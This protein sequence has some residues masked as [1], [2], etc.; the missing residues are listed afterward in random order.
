MT[1]KPNN[2]IKRRS[3]AGRPA[4]QPN[5][6][7][8]RT[9]C[10]FNPSDEELSAAIGVNPST[11]VIWKKKPEVLEAMQ[12]GKAQGRMSLR[13][14]QFDKAMKGSDTML[15]WLGKQLLDQKEKSLLGEDPDSPFVTIIND[16]KR[17]PKG[18]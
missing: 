4:I 8:I 9:L 3:K 7:Q 1:K 17:P 15:I 18:D 16:V 11:M 12:A 5:L 2:R 6:E 14:K 13:G 10:R